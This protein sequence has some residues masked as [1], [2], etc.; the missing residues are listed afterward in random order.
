M[1]AEPMTQVLNRARPVK[2]DAGHVFDE[3]TRIG[4]EWRRLIDAR[5]L[6]REAS[7]RSREQA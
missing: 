2:K 3:L 5:V 1:L 6:L 7:V 4:P